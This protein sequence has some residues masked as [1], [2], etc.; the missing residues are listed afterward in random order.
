MRKAIL[1]RSKKKSW[2][3]ATPTND[4]H[5]CCLSC[6]FLKQFVGADFI[7]LH[8]ARLRLEL[9]PKVAHGRG[10][11][12]LILPRDSSILNRFLNPP[13]ILADHWAPVRRRRVRRIFKIAFLFVHF[14][15]RCRT[16]RQVGSHIDIRDLDISNDPFFINK[17]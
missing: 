6:L 10:Q 17:Y 3:K 5:Q 16:L 14:F 8:L 2:L 15:Q 1:T 9:R 11:S 4:S 13:S 12:S 7:E